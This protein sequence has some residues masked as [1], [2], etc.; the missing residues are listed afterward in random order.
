MANTENLETTEINDLIVELIIARMPV[1]VRGVLK[2]KKLDELSGRVKISKSFPEFLADLG[3]NF[4]GATE[5]LRELTGRPDIKLDSLAFGYRGDPKFVTVAVTFTAGDS[6]CRFVCLKSSGTQGGFVAGLELRLQNDLF[7]NNPLSGLIGEISLGDMGIYYA[8]DDFPNVEYDPRQE[9]QD[10]DALVP[11]AQPQVGARNFTK[12]M[13]WSA[14]ILIAGVDLLEKL[15][16]LDKPKP[17]VATAPAQPRDNPPKPQLTDQTTWIDV[18]KTLGPL[19]VQRIGL[20]Y[21]APRVVVKIDASLQLSVLTLSLQ[22]LGVSY[23]LNRFADLIKPREFF[24]HLGFQLDGAAL[25]LQQGGLAIS[26]G[27]LNVSEAGASLRLDGALVIRTEVFSISALGSYAQTSFGPSLFIFAVLH[28]DLGGPSF[29]HV[30]GLAVGFGY[31]RKLKL[32]PIEEVQSFPLVRAALDEKYLLSSGA[33]IPIQAALAKLRDYISISHGDYWLAVGI[34]FSSFEMVLS[35]ALLSV[36]F[37]NEVEI[38]LLGLSTLTIPKFAPPGQAI[39]YAE[40]A[41]RAVIKPAEGLISVEARLTSESYVFSRD[42]HLT[43][44]FA[45]YTWFSGPYAGDFVVTLG[46]YHPR[47]LRPAHYPLV[48]RLGVNWRVT[49]ELTITGEYYCALT[50]SCLMAGGKLSAVYRSGCIKAWFIAYADFLLNWKPFYY[51]VDMGISIGVEATLRIPLV[52]FTISISISVH[53]SVGLHIWGPEFAGRIEVDLSV[54]TFTISFGPPKAPPAPI[55]AAEFVASFLPA[56]Q[57]VIAAQI[58]SGLIA[59]QKDDTGTHRVVNA[60]A[61]ALTTRS[62]IPVS[63]FTGL[64]P[65]QNLLASSQEKLGI[66]SMGKTQLTSSYGVTIKRDGQDVTKDIYNARISVVKTAVP[67]ALWG[68]SDR[69]GQVKLATVPQAKTLEVSAGLRISF[70][71]KHPQGALPAMEIEKFKYETF[72]KPIPWDDSLIP[73]QTLPAAEQGLGIV[74][75]MGNQA[76]RNRNAVLAV[77]SANTGPADLELQSRLPSF[78]QV[79]LERLVKAGASYFQ[80][81]PEVA[82]LGQRFV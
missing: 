82:R 34:R 52:F 36:S 79:N 28:R 11:A 55:P 47:F 25:A 12:G 61:L 70:D 77:L 65:R 72:N 64:A 39:V 81:N 24:R 69:D 4:T 19:S 67:E 29:F 22:G 1:K 26:G 71:P 16:T 43:G 56:K 9:F 76:T 40:L 10:G 66:R 68:P 74:E 54:I 57:E 53:L 50:P 18:K 8:S 73:A 42:C 15:R 78:N 63:N 58:S 45:F 44:G 6:R 38:G 3:A 80:A 46:G 27:L 31:N 20:R 14:Q 21:E 49:S 17:V 35:F 32:P 2:D 5:T 51:L 7:K 60:H 48:P 33:E 59:E 37:G 23:P 62:V 41:L 13:N 30:T 75:V